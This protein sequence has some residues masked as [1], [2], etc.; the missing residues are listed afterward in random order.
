MKFLIY[1]D[2]LIR[3]STAGGRYIVIK[4]QITQSQKY[5]L[6]PYI[7]ITLVVVELE[8]I[9]KKNIL[10]AILMRNPF[11]RSKLPYLEK[12]GSSNTKNNTNT[13]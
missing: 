2:I 8:T 5:L 6:F 7:S 11:L 3:K 10:A 12:I 4:L 1:F 9:S 13:P